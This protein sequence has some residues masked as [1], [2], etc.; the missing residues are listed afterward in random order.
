MNIKRLF[1]LIVAGAMLMSAQTSFEQAVDRYFADRFKFLPS[2]ATSDGFH[3]YDSQLED[4]SAREIPARA[5]MDRKYL[6][7]FGRMPAS[8]DRDLMMSKIQ[9]DLLSIEEI[10][11]WE[12]N[13]DV[14]SS[15]ITESVFGL[16]SRNFAPPDHRLRSV[17]AR[18]EQMPRVLQ[19]AR[20]NLKNPP[21]IY[22]QVAIEQLPGIIDFFRS[23]VPA[24]F[25]GV[26]DGALLSEFHQKNNA[27]IAALESYQQFL[28][29]DILPKSNGDFRI[30]AEKLS[31]EAAVRRDGGHS[32]RPAAADRL[33]QPPRESA[34]S[35]LKLS[36]KIGCLQICSG[37]SGPDGA[38]PSRRPTSFW[39][40]S[41]TRWAV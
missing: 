10:R 36:K 4:Y 13:P 29:S 11:S 40:L 25:S 41:A 12:N 3:Q 26:H 18:E 14:Y 9:S 15:G 1:L 5:E 34:S 28:Q 7:E 2:E 37:D 16:I 39:I 17:I 23:D 6:A 31:E 38:R 32:A 21:R 30:G 35:C 24:A 8:A 22:T 27:V 19:N 33:R 20:E